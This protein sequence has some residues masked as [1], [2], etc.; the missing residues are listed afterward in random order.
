MFITCRDNQ[1][2]SAA[3]LVEQ[4]LGLLTADCQ[5][6]E[7]VLLPHVTVNDH[8]IVLNGELAF[9]HL[10][11]MTVDGTTIVDDVVERAE[12]IEEYRMGVVDLQ[13]RLHQLAK[14]DGHMVTVVTFPQAFKDVYTLRRDVQR[15]GETEYGR[16]G[17]TR[18]GRFRL[19]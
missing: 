5:C 7:I 15:I 18:R 6:A 10:E 3:A 19:G 4:Q 16:Y 2:A 11:Q 8:A 17:L 9:V 1:Q 13:P 14:V 12:A